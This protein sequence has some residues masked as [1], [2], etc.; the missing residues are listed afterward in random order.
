MAILKQVI[1]SIK[2]R[3]WKAKPGAI[4][5]IP[6]RSEQKLSNF[7]KIFKPVDWKGQS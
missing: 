3:S 5:S 2:S 4:T 7:R 6:G 1:E